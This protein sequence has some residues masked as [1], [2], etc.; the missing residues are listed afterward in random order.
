[1]SGYGN[2][3]EKAIRKIL[4]HLERGLGYSDAVLAAGY[5]HH[6]DFRNPEE[7]HESLPYY[8]EVLTRDAVGADPEERP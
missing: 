5:P 7:A 3:S 8:G 1:M 2:L 6:S 4:P